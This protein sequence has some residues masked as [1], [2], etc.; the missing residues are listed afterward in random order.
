MGKLFT[1][2]LTVAC[3][4]TL[5]SLFLSLLL[6]LAPVIAVIFGMV[7]TAGILVMLTNLPRRGPP[8]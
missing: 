1:V 6:L 8:Q 4:V 2:L 5:S 7:L 3:V